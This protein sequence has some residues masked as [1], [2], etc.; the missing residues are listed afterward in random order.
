[1]RVRGRTKVAP[2]ASEQAVRAVGA[3]RVVFGSDDRQEEAL[4]AMGRLSLSETDRAAIMGGNAARLL[5]EEG[6]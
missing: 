6:W 1:V 5:G 4:R 2:T 3:E